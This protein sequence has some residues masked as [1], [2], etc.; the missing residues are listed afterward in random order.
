MTPKEG[1]TA[2]NSPKAIDAFLSQLDG[3]WLV[4]PNLRQHCFLAK[5]GEDMLL[6]HI[7][8]GRTLIDFSCVPGESDSVRMS[9]DILAWQEDLLEL[10]DRLSREQPYSTYIY[11]QDARELLQPYIERET[12]S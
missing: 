12:A 3:T 4:D 11:V 9:E 1:A 6:S 2:F 8:V 7:S 5:M 10:S